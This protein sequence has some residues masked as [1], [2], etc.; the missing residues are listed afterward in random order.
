MNSPSVP[1]VVAG[2]R[3]FKAVHINTTESKSYLR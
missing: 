1:K 3:G 2:G